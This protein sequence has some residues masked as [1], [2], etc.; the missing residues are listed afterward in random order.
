MKN[1]LSLLLILMLSLVACGDNNDTDL[2]ALDPQALEKMDGL[3]EAPSSQSDECFQITS[4]KLSM[5]SN[6]LTTEVMAKS[7]LKDKDKEISL[8][9]FIESSQQTL[10]NSI[11]LQVLEL[12]KFAYQTQS[13]L[14]TNIKKV[15]LPKT[16]GVAN[17]PAARFNIKN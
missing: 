16:I 2:A 13:Q 4:I 12:I 1:S 9:R 15:C 3:A 11:D 8:I 7:L 14:C 10:N 17:C 6:G 5:S